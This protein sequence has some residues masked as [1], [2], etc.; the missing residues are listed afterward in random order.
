MAARI[1][2]SIELPDGRCLAYNEYGDPAGQPLF[3][4]HAAFF[5]RTFGEPVDNPAT[6][7][8][9]RVIC[10]DRPGVGRS[11]FTPWTFADAP[12][13][14]ARLADA[15]RLETFA[16]VGVSGGGAH[17]M[18]AAWQLPERLTAVG[19]VSSVAPPVP[20]V[21]A[22]LSRTNPLRNPA[23]RRP[24]LWRPQ[25]W[26]LSLLLRHRPGL[27]ATIMGR[28]LD[29]SDRA[30]LRR[31]ETRDYFERSMREAMR[32][33]GRGWAHEGCRTG[34]PS[35]AA[36]LPEIRTPV[37][38]WQGEADRFAP[39]V[40][41]DYLARTIPDCART[42]VPDA[43]HLWGIDHMDEVLDTLLP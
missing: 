4:L 35:W 21:V 9:I 33:G 34:S 41:G 25:M 14:L 30:V 31:A 12:A 39:P 24:W 6:Q 2:Q 16:V 3:L 28:A 19:L 37:H 8:G 7:R 43:G 22:S 1:D 11:D 5:A 17:A 13:D 36:W 32:Q 29:A 38:L 26:G 27:A 23:R 40:M 10:P 15:L 18:A 20:D 42:I